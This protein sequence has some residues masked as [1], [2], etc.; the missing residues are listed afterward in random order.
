MNSG[1]S[2]VSIANSIW[3]AENLERRPPRNGNEGNS[4]DFGRSYRQGGWR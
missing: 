4:V 3:M 1:L 2:G